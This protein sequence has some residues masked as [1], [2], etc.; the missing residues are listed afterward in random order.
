VGDPLTPL[1]REY[2]LEALESVDQ[3]AVLVGGQAV[4]WWA[5]YYGMRGRLPAIDEPM[6]MYVSKD[7]DFAARSLDPR[8]LRPMVKE[9]AVRLHGSPHFKFPFT[10]LV[11]A[12]VTFTDDEGEERTVE[13]LKGVH[14]IRGR[15]RVLDQAVGFEAT[16]D[17]PSFYVI[18][19]VMLLESRAANVVELD[20]YQTDT[21]IL[22]ARIARDVLREWHLDK[23]AD[24]WDE[25]RQ[26]IERTLKLAEHKRGIAIAAKYDVDVIASVP[27]DHDALPPQF[28]E[29]R[30]EPCREKVAA[31]IAAARASSS[32]GRGG[33]PTP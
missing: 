29:K 32:G 13:F 5:E 8:E 20:G 7:A 24:G 33:P 10:S 15:D 21:G 22:Q 28:L 16:D 9:L 19:P 1:K 11:V 14:G 27:C 30:L 3:G 23:L 6:A 2:V 31:A 12:S 18:H 17:L 4:A 25:A 26:G